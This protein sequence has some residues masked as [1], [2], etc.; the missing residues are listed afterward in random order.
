MEV[1]NKEASKYAKKKTGRKQDEQ[2][3]LTRIETPA[4]TEETPSYAEPMAEE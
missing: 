1:I 2:P 3:L 4:Q